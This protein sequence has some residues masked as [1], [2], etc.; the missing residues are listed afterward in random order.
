MAAAWGLIGLTGGAAVR[1]ASLPPAP[2]IP[3]GLRILSEVTLPSALARACDIRWAGERSVYLGLGVDGTVE[4]RLDAAGA[5]AKEVIPGRSKPGGFSATHRIAASAKYLVAA[6]PAFWVTWR[7][8]DDPV[9]SDAAFE[10]IQAIDLRD[11][12]LALVGA[13]RDERGKFGADGAIAWTGS[14]DKRLTDLKPLLYDAGGPGAPTMNRCLGAE[15]GATRFLADGSLFVLPGVQ[16]GASLFDREGKLVRTWD[17]AALGIDA[18]CTGLSEA[19]A[20][21]LAASYEQRQVW[22]NQRH[23]VDAVLPLPEG[24]GLLVRRVEKGRTRWD[25]KVLRRE[26]PVKT[27]AVP[28]EGSSE[29]FALGG[30]VRAGRIVLLLHEKTLRGREHQLPRTIEAS[31]PAG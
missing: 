4:V 26:G 13:R 2:P 24:P 8:L 19:V 17:T 5:A 25:L 15:L 14:L 31:L 1:P 20:A 3:A 21:H 28:L 23:L 10:A 12:Q 6:G 18:D 29:F 11:G 22:I 7:R 16:P 27:I 9:R 30:D